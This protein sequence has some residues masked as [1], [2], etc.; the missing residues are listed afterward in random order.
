MSLVQDDMEIL[1]QLSVMQDAHDYKFLWA[2]N[3][4]L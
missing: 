4:E 3:P 1:T 2:K